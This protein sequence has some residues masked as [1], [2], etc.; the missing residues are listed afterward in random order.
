MKILLVGGGGREHALAWKIKQSPQADEIFCA[1][2]NAG[3]AEVAKNVAIPADDIDQLL[4]FALDNKIDMTVVGP[5]DPLVMGLAD[6]FAERDLK[7]FGPSAAA[8]RIEG[9]K[10][11]AKDLMKKHNIPTG[12]Y[13]TFDNAAS[14]KAY[15]KGK[16]ALV[17]KA[18]G[19]AAGKGVFVCRDSAEALHAIAQ[20]MEQKAFGTAGNQILIEEKL[21]GQEVSFL[22]F[23]DSKTLLP[24]AAVQDHK[25]AYDNDQGPNTRGTGG[26]P[27]DGTRRPVR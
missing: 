25:P 23:T 5:E 21:E 24:M 3:T 10:V 17:V 11:F 2:G 27:G 13:E 7:V 15:V 1:P 16:G 18:D 12:E 4:Q 8:A 19:L 22:A 20:I 6:R 9:S 26:P 14:A